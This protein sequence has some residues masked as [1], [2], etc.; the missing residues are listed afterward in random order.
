MSSIRLSRG[1]RRRME[2]LRL[3]VKAG[4]HDRRYCPI[5][6]ETEP[7]EKEKL[8][9]SLIDAESG[10][11]VPSQSDFLENSTKVKVHWIVQSLGKDEEKEYAVRFARQPQVSSQD[12][13]VSVKEE[14]E[15]KVDVHVRGNP[16][17]AYNFGANAIRPYIYPVFGPGGR[18]VTR[19]FPMMPDVS[20]E[21]RDHPHHRSIW[22]AHGN[23]SGVD[24]WSE[25]DNCGRI[26]HRSFKTLRSGPVFGE[27]ASINDWV[28]HEGEKV[29]GEERRVIV[30]DAPESLRIMDLEVNFRAIDEDAKFGDTKEG[31]I[32]SVRVASSM[33]VV[34]GGRIE[35]AYGGINEDETW[36]RRAHWCDYSGPVGGS[37]M[38]IAIF[39]HS[40]NFRHPTYWHVRDYGLMTANPFGVSYFTGDAKKDGSFTLRK[41]ESLR[42]RY[43][44]LIHEGDAE[45][46]WVKHG[47]HDFVNP[48]KVAIS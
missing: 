47:Y 20:G 15:S 6:A 30:Y 27:I 46:G 31:G 5:S 34:N 39:D 38:G 22:T 36:G 43:R 18:L 48:P 13:R 26:L 3:I 19:S 32:I 29:L 45:T 7:P 9:I 11:L 40:R 1:W 24:D 4:N 42:F 10:E 28:S 21:T 2:E 41:G 14:A 37:W 12:L 35:N 44:I 33:D 16:F 8:K 23:V 17:I 25:A